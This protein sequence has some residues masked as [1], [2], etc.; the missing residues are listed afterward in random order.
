MT[1]RIAMISEHASPLAVIGGVDSGGQNVYVANTARNLARLGYQVDIFTRKDD[2]KT[3]D[4][5]NWE[6]GVRIIHVP[7][8]PQKFIPKEELLPYMDDFTSYVKEFIQQKGISYGIVHAHFWMSA[9]VAADLKKELGLPFV[10]TFHALG[11]VRRKHQGEEDHFPDIRFQVEERVVAE[12]DRIIAE[13]PQDELDL[14]YLY[15][16]DPEKVVIIPCGFDPA[17][18]WPMDKSLS[19]K[20][21]GIPKEERV[22]LQ[23][24][25]M[26]PRKGI[27]TVLR[28]FSRMVK[29]Y[30]LSARLLLVGG[31]TSEPDPESTP[32]IGRLQGIAEEEG[33][34]DM[35][36][37]T[38]QRSRKE[39]KHYYSAADVFV[40]TPWYEPFGITPVEA[41]ACGTPVI[42]SKV[43]GIKYTVCDGET[44]YLIPPDDPLALAERLAHLFQ[45]PG[46][47]K[48]FSQN[49]VRRANKLFTWQKVTA[50]IA[51]LY[52][53][54]TGSSP[55]VEA[56]NQLTKNGGTGLKSKQTSLIAFDTA[57]DDLIQSLQLSKKVLSGTTLKAAETIANCLAR[58]NKVM[59][60]GNGGSAADAQH[61]AAEFV[62][63]FAVPGRKAL[64]VL[65]LTSETA[66]L[67]A[68][69]NDIG[70]ENV[71]SRQ[72]EAFG[73]PGDVL[74]AISTS[75][76][77][78]N[79]VEA[80]KTAAAL[81]IKCIGLIGRDGGDL[82]AWAD[83][84]VIIPTSNTQRIQEVQLL[85][86]HVISELVEDRFVP[87]RLLTKSTI[88]AGKKTKKGWRVQSSVPVRLQQ[89]K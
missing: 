22:V 41:M 80:F 86:L 16:A 24:G 53:E 32:E 6:K 63:R 81:D 33:I 66:F 55:S 61:F 9:L 15:D 74:I 87:D 35:V 70:Y 21:L 11:K 59:V 75:G 17:E 28:G 88:P 29:D 36:T 43:G 23:I 14:R 50:E 18:M 1:H 76:K 64:P 56:A 48:I 7:A 10:V 42:G 69:S 31:E 46:E 45:N 71:F 79:L 58:G 52:E 2:K 83:I 65:A 12:A 47:L 72:L 39:L 26:V 51:S 68:W 85:I 8:G 82:L 67:T 57:I 54:M 78:Q 38:G 27:E 84:P 25:R 34:S 5:Y 77:S 30:G 19:R 4:I 73:Q 3:P 62:G 89:T 49:S 13:C 60:C 37:F 20:L 40:S 44:G